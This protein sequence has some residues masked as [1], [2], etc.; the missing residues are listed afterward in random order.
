M[1]PAT[2]LDLKTS[3][4]RSS[5]CDYGDAYMLFK[6]IITVP[7]MT[8]ALAARNNANEKVIFKSCALF[9]NFISRINS[10][11]VDDAYNIDVV[12]PMYNLIE[13]ID[14]YFKTSGTLWKYYRDEPAVNAAN[15]NVVD[16]NETNPICNLFKIKEKTTRQLNLI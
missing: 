16:F 13:Y 14:N 2:K 1:T 7:N 5:L 4:I 9:T 3:I 11:Q 12:I 10:I 15:G 8:V 6:G